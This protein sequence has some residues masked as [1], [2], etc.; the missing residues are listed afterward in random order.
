MYSFRTL[1]KRVGDAPRGAVLQVFKGDVKWATDVLA[2]IL[3]NSKL[4]QSG[5]EHERNII[6]REMQEV[7][8]GW[9]GGGGGG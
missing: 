2:D 1:L 8:G 4:D 9:E 7:G 6:L 3:Q 5:I